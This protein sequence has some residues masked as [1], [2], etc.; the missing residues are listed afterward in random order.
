MWSRLVSTR[1]SQRSITAPTPSIAKGHEAGGW[2]GEEGSF[3]LSQRLLGTL[4]IPVYLHGGIGLHTAAAA[5]VAGAAGAVLDA[6]LLLARESPL[7][8]SLRATLAGVDGSETVTLGA[9]LGAPF[10]AYSRPGLHSLEQLRAVEEELLASADARGGVARGRQRRD[11]GG[12]GT[13]AAVL[14]LGQDAAFAAELAR[15]FDTVAGI[16]DGLRAAIARR[17]RDARGR[18]SAGR[19]RR[20]RRG[21]TAPA[22]RSSRGR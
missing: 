8:D 10:R 21:R 15:R 2:I 11:V 17:L 18:Q 6:Q 14:P 5:Y 13:D 7:P 9:R 1:P 16:I 19:G 22:I 4:S 3:V 20:R 12:A